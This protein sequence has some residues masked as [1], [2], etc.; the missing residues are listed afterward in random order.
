MW[1]R[2][3][4]GFGPEEDGYVGWSKEVGRAHILKHIQDGDLIMIYGA[5][6]SE[7]EK[8]LRS[9]IL[10]FVQVDATAIRDVDKAS[11]EALAR[12]AQLG[13]A[14]KWTYGIPIRRA[15]RTTEKL[16][17]SQIASKTYRPEAGQAIGVWGAELTPEEISEAL[18]IKVTEVNVFGEP[19]IS[20][21]TISNEPFLNAFKPS[22]GF[23]G[24]SGERTSKYED[25]D[26][27]VYL[28]RF[29]GKG[30]AL[31][32]KPTPHGDKAVLMKI[33]VTNQR[34]RREDELNVGIP[35]AAVGRWKIKLISQPYADRKSA[36]TVEQTFK[37]QG[38]LKLESLGKEFFWGE[39]M[40]ALLLFTSL[41]GTSRF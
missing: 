21:Q 7:T 28:A 2:A 30:H 11:P 27:Y 3:F 19:P 14:E 24:F 9:Y 8:S 41:P 6:S 33:G 20:N 13:W 16:M 29:E 5:G 25:G 18:K 22:R 40:T 36:E 26:T 38:E 10:G 31:V 12:K 4:Y 15:W 35:P 23:P 1:I 32:G 39:W 34:K 17:I 37:D